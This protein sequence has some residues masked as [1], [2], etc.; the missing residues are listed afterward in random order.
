MGLWTPSAFFSSTAIYTY[1]C[2]G[3]SED[4]SRKRRM[5]QS[6]NL[7]PVS[8]NHNYNDNTKDEGELRGRK[9]PNPSPRKASRCEI[10]L[11]DDPVQSPLE[12]IFFDLP[13]ELLVE[14]ATYL[15]PLDIIKLARVNTTIRALLMRRS[16]AC[17]WRTVLRTANALPPIS[18]E[19]PEPLLAA[20]LF[21]AECTICSR[22][23]DETVDF[24]LQV[25]LCSE[26]RDTELILITDIGF[27][28]SKLL[29]TSISKG[30]S[31]GSIR[32]ARL[33]SKWFKIW[34][35]RRPIKERLSRKER[36]QVTNARVADIEARV[37]GM[38]YQFFEVQ[39]F[40][41]LQPRKWPWELFLPHLLHHLETERKRKRCLI[42]QPTLDGVLLR[43]QNRLRP[44]VCI[45]VQS[46]ADDQAS[47][48]L[49]DSNNS[50]RGPVNSYTN[51]LDNNM[52][53]PSF[54]HKT[55]ILLICAEVRAMMEAQT[56]WDAFEL[57]IQTMDSNI[58]HA[59]Q[60]WRDV[61]ELTLLNLLPTDTQPAEIEGFKYKLILG[62]S[63]DARPLD[64][65]SVE[66]RKLLRADSIFCMQPEFGSLNGGGLLYYPEDF[67]GQFMMRN[68]PKLRYHYLAAKIASALLCVIGYPDASHIAMNTTARL[69]QC[70]RCD[71]K[72]IFYLWAELLQHYMRNSRAN[73]TTNYSLAGFW[74]PAP[75][76]TDLDMSMH[77]VDSVYSN[78]PLVQL[79]DEAAYIPDLTIL[80]NPENFVCLVCLAANGPTDTYMSAENIQYYFQNAHLIDEP[81]EGAHYV[82]TSAVSDLSPIYQQ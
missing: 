7:G 18:S 1:D 28:N 39:Q 24:F 10:S 3:L 34:T 62:T 44:V 31:V 8:L 57:E 52:T 38:G 42:R 79:V 17:I 16:A 45:Q 67:Q 66:C 6:T 23:T 74:S 72:P 65:L 61:L 11:L 48:L 76:A 14:V 27:V 13:L 15:R 32:S 78:K 59:A 63:E 64:L 37:Y 20:L 70:G 12:K 40:R 47:L 75:E 29:H 33:L 35:K 2:T 69:Y 82:R 77:D 56:P 80:S 30:A 5:N 4:P 60:A 73:Q 43:I 68:R 81:I 19:L 25:K 41:A 58:E 36:R 49:S 53:L 26:C 46:D 55:D 9:S 22:Y 51:S 50:I 71:D 54:P 21:L